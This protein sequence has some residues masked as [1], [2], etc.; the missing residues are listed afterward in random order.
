MILFTRSGGNA[1]HLGS[2]SAFMGGVVLRTL[3]VPLFTFL[4][5]A[6]NS[7]SSRPPNSAID[8][9][10]GLFFS[11]ILSVFCLVFFPK[12]SK[13]TV[14]NF[15]QTWTKKDGNTFS[16]QAFFFFKGKKCLHYIAY[17]G[18]VLFVVFCLKF[19]Q[20]R[21]WI[22]TVLAANCCWSMLKGPNIQNGS[23]FQ[24]NYNP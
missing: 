8:Q 3:V 1:Q 19:W 4:S 21:T 16:S 10:V 23:C 14:F 20:H 17:L 12:F 7:L 6:A 5:V 11:H 9:Q 18:F 15:C 13:S 2:F 22:W 24:I